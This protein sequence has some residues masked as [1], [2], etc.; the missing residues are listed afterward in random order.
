[1]SEEEKKAEVPAAEGEAKK[2]VKKEE[3]KKKPLTSVKSLGI[4]HDRNARYRRTMEDAHVWVDGFAD[5]AK[6]GFFAIYDGHGGR[7]A[8]EF[9][10]KTLHVN[11]QAELAKD[12]TDVES[13]WMRTYKLTDDQVDENKIQYSGTTTV[14]AFIRVEGDK[15]M[16][17]V[18]NVGDARAVISH[19]GKAERLTYDHK[20]S[21]EAEVARV[22]EAGGFVVMGRV[23]GILAVTRSLGDRAMK[24]YV[25]GEPYCRSLELKED[26]THLILACDGIW[27]VISDQEAV[28]LVGKHEACGEASRQLLITALKNGSTDNISVMVIAL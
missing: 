24:D 8:V 21:D 3:K 7:Q 10:A 5:D 18:A 4:S 12:P 23:N 1:M 25:V 13:A 11:F 14:T 22:K 26:D 17:Y 20:G 15:R 2:E 28:E 9:V 27:D 16:L 19:G 6:Q